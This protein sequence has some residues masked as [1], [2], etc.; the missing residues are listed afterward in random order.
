VISYSIVKGILK[1]NIL[2]FVEKYYWIS[3]KLTG[4]N[5]EQYWIRMVFQLF[6]IVFFASPIVF[7]HKG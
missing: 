6:P 5:S 1:E 2:S 4:T 7:F 3:E